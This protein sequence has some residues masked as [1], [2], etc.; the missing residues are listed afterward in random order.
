M[1]QEYNVKIVLTLHTSLL[2]LITQKVY[3]SLIPS[4]YSMVK[5]VLEQNFK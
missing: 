3:I 1:L 4:F 2:R 5:N